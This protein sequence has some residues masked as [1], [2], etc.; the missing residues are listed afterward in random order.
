MKKL[1]L[2]LFCVNIIVGLASY[3]DYTC[4]QMRSCE[5]AKKH[6]TKNHRH[7]DRDGDGVPCESICPG[8]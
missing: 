4:K 3:P 1:I 2:T 8:G 7:L 6:T 5:E